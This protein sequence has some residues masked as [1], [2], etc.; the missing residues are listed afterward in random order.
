MVISTTRRC[1]A[2]VRVGGFAGGAAGD[3][4]RDAVGDLPL[5]VRVQSGFVDGAVGTERE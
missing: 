3:E 1:S 5:D 4:Q 2:S